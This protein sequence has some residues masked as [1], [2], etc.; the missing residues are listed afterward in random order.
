MRCAANR[1]NLTTTNQNIKYAGSILLIIFC[2]GNE[3]YT[4]LGFE[5]DVDT[6]H[7][8]IYQNKRPICGDDN[9]Q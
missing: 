4:H 5:Y 7:I 9:T 3:Q 6:K 2:D 1:L 8:D